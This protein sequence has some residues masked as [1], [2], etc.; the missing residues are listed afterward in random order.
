MADG[1]T[2]VALPR[3]RILEA[4]RMQA[5]CPEMRARDGEKRKVRVRNEK[6]KE[7]TREVEIQ[8]SSLSTVEIL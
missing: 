6:R 8:S 5:R 7:I 3:R 2:A 4:E 1:A